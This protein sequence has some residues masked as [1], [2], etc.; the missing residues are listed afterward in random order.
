MTEWD[1]FVENVATV[2]EATTLR[3]LVP[4]V[5]PA[6]LRSFIDARLGEESPEQFA[7]DIAGE[8]CNH[9]TR[10]QCELLVRR[11][12]E[13]DVQATVLYGFA[14]ALRRLA[15]AA[16]R[17]GVQSHRLFDWER[18]PRARLDHGDLVADDRRALA[19][20]ASNA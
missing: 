7:Y 11:L 20:E 17:D 19:R 8:L 6:A 15:V 14:E 1:E 3:D 12:A 5:T 9:G 18:T 10:E 2:T 16:L 13:P 4:L